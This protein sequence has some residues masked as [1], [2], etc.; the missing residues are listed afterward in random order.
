MMMRGKGEIE[1][2]LNFGKEE[3]VI[4]RSVMLSV[5]KIIIMGVIIFVVIFIVIILRV[6]MKIIILMRMMV[7]F[8]Y[9][10]DVGVMIVNF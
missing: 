3:S 4:V 10:I 1:R 8:E 5:E 7:G 9:F 2:N 6:V